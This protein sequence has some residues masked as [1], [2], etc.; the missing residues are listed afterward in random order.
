MAKLMGSKDVYKNS[1]KLSRGDDGKMGVHAK[2]EADKPA[3]ASGETETDEAKEGM[4]VSDNDVHARHNLDRHMMHA[5]H[6]HEHSG[7]KGGDKAEMHAR[8][9]TEIKAMLKKHE[10]ELGGSDQHDAAMSKD[11][12]D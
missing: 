9:N 4:P 12:K 11:G 3:A 10:E 5:K 6:E 2:K 1:P 8:H 7:H